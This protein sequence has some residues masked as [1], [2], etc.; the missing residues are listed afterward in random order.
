MVESSKIQKHRK[1][2]T[3][4]VIQKALAGIYSIFC[5]TPEGVK[6][7]SPFTGHSEA[8]NIFLTK[9]RG[10]GPPGG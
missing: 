5:Q 4:T 9:I 1:G 3:L 6:I 8:L 10:K 7:K 2:Q